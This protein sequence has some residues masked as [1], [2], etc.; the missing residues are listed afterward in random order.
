MRA[1]SHDTIEC[2]RAIEF[3]LATIRCLGARIAPGNTE[4]DYRDIELQENSAQFLI[5]SSLYMS[6]LCDATLMYP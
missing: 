3:T 6:S 2:I 5:K 1:I 4:E